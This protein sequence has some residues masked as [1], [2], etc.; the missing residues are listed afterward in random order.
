MLQPQ[1]QW[2]AWVSGP[3]IIL[4]QP[5]QG[6]S[7]K[8]YCVKKLKT[9]W[10][11]F[12]CFHP[13]GNWVIITKFCTWQH[14]CHNFKKFVVTFIWEINLSQ[15][16]IMLFLFGLNLCKNQ[17]WNGLLLSSM[18]ER[19]DPGQNHHYTDVTMSPNASQITSLRIVYSTVYSCA[20][21]RKYQSSTSLAFV[22]RIH[23]GPVNSPHKGPVTRKM[24]PFDDVIMQCTYGC[25]KLK[26]RAPQHGG[27]L[28]RLG[29]FQCDSVVV[30]RLQWM[31][32]AGFGYLMRIFVKAIE[33]FCKWPD[34]ARRGGDFS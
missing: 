23:R 15:N 22:R 20:D 31:I 34:K 3:F 1:V 18:I 11:Y 5:M 28:T 29:L 4:H 32:L 7:Q 25:P 10:K 21:Q 6:P 19:Q 14:S 12:V 30:T 17:Y 33:F 16:H 26:F 13:S 24:F 9:G 2:I 8:W 27:G